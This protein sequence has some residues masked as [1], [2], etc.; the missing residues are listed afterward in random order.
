VLR[1]KVRRD[2]EVLKVAHREEDPRPLQRIRL[3]DGD[4]PRSAACNAN[5][6]RSANAIAQA[7]T[8]I[9]RLLLQR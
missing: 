6:R 3:G 9:Q 5:G 4:Q 2:R 7:Q 8:P 1:C